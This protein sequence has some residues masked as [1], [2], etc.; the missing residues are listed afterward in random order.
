MVE[1]KE[2]LKSLFRL[3][4]DFAKEKLVNEQEHSSLRESNAKKLASMQA[5][6]ERLTKIVNAGIPKDVIDKALAV[7]EKKPEKTNGETQVHAVGEDTSKPVVRDI[8]D[9]KKSTAIK[10]KVAK[11][12]SVIRHPPNRK[13]GILMLTGILMCAFVAYAVIWPSLLIGG[14]GIIT[15]TAGLVIYT[16]LSKAEL[17]T[18]VPFGDIE[19]GTIANY[20]CYIWNSANTTLNVTAIASHWNP[21]TPNIGD[22]ALQYQPLMIPVNSGVNA[23]L[24]LSAATNAPSGS[25]TVDIEIRGT[26]VP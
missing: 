22:I 8:T 5:E 15:N 25:F 2:I 6:I 18:F 4:G 1:L 24:Q 10:A 20:T 23:T 11:I 13:V 7:E 12:V 14:N 3:K 16:N 21:T 17:L 26:V 19:N 9:E